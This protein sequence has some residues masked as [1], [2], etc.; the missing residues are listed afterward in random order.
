MARLQVEAEWEGVKRDHLS[1][2]VKIL[3]SREETH[4]RRFCEPEL[5]PPLY[6]WV[7]SRSSKKAFGILHDQ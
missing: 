7:S 3:R 2:S 5:T 6:P 1:E 4:Q